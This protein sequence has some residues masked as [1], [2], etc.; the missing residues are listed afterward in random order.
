MFMRFLKVKNMNKHPR[1]RAGQKL[2]FLNS[3]DP[4]CSYMNFKQTC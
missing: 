2:V 3:I 1:G 4:S